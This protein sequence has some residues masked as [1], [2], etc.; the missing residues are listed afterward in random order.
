MHPRN[1]TTRASAVN[2]YQALHCNGANVEIRDHVGDENIF[3]FGLT[4]DQVAGLRR[5]GYRPRDAIDANPALSEALKQIQ[6]GVFSPDDKDR[7]R[8]LIQNLIDSDWFL[9]TADFSTYYDMQRHADQV[10]LDQKEWNR[11]AILNTARVGWFSSDRTIRQYASE[12][13]NVPT[14]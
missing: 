5:D 10:W 12:I 14:D 3:I 6:S 8:D 4:A 2:Y 11:I 13:W 1:Y 7:Y 9:V